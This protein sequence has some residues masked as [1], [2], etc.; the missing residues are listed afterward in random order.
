MHKDALTRLGNGVYSFSDHGFG[1]VVGGHHQ[2][3]NGNDDTSGV[4]L[5]DPQYAYQKAELLQELV[6]KGS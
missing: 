2:N 5:D 4:W 3:A 6:S 1:V